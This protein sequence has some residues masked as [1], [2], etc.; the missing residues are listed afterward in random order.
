MTVSASV[1]DSP[2]KVCPLL[3]GAAIP[4]VALQT[5]DGEPFDVNRAVSQRPSVL[6]FYRG[7]W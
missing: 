7:G 2:E 3:V 5:V 6:V 4:Q 1:A